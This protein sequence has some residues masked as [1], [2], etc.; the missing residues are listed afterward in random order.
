MNDND[1]VYKDIND[2]QLLPPSYSKNTSQ[3]Q[4]HHPLHSNIHNQHDQLHNHNHINHIN[5]KNEINN[6]KRKTICTSTEIFNSCRYVF[7]FSV[8]QHHLELRGTLMILHYLLWH[9][10]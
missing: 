5:T 8:I 2:H 3:S 10:Q 6:I 1:I 9:W 7:V 4:L